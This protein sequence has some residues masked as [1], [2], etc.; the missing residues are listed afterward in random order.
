MTVGWRL[1]G[2]A[3]GGARGPAAR[4]GAGLDVP[5]RPRARIG[6][7]ATHEQTLTNSELRVLETHIYA[8]THGSGATTAK[9]FVGTGLLPDAGSPAI[10]MG[11]LVSWS[12]AGL[13]ED[14]DGD[15]IPTSNDACPYTAEDR[16][17]Y[18]DRD[19]CP[20]PDRDLDD[21]P[22][23]VDE[24]PEDPEDRDGYQDR[25]GCP[26]ADNDFDGL[27]DAVDT[28][29]MQAGPASTAGCPDEDDD[30]LA[31]R[32]DE[33]PAQPG[34][35]SSFGCPDWDGD[36]VPNIRDACPAQP[37]EPTIDPRWSDG[38]PTAVWRGKGQI[39]H[40]DPV[41]FAFNRASVDPRSIPTL[42]EIA[43]IIRSN[44]DILLVEIAGHADEVGSRFYNRRLSRLR[45]AAVRHV[46]ITEGGVEPDRV[47]AVGYG[48]ERPIGDNT[49][50]AG[51][52][53]NRRVEFRIRRTSEA[54]NAPTLRSSP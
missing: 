41:Y 14:P 51:R 33:C 49:T 34:P 8:S 9:A 3:F 20:D 1:N 37:A 38:C 19:G 13:E 12:R 44:P 23:A 5:L 36:R 25:D 39:L 54:P 18:T 24:C 45:A 22:D 6:V 16:D 48:E 52:A 29:P 21:V 46:L 27:P 11:L 10:R 43:S 42:I 26:D 47:I 50:E 17:G 32:E 2:G 4:L 15:G 7:E 30:G 31:D 35:S 28:C 53:E 40:E